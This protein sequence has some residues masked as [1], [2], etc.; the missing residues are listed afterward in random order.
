MTPTLEDQGNT[1]RCGVFSVVQWF[2]GNGFANV[3][4]LSPFSKYCSLADSQQGLAFSQVHDEVEEFCSALSITPEWLQDGYLKDFNTFNQAISDGW[5]VVVGVYEQDIKPGQ[6]YYHY[7]DIY[8]FNGNNYLIRDSFH[9]YDGEHGQEP[10]DAV[11]KAIKD[12]WDTNV[13]GLAFK[14]KNANAPSMNDQLVTILSVIGD[15]TYQNPADLVGI[16]VLVQ[17]AKKLLGA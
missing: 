16:Q 17:Q 10:V 11:I 15:K 3:Q 5:C 2:E 13:S 1:Y 6:R 12:N 14:I 7:I 8:G 4:S 9:K